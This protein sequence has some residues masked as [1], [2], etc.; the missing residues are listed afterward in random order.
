[1][2]N[3]LCHTGHLEKYRGFAK[4]GEGGHVYTPCT[5]S[6]GSY[7]YDYTTFPASLFRM[8]FIFAHAQTMKKRI[9]DSAQFYQYS[10]AVTC[11]QVYMDY[12]TCDLHMALLTTSY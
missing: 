10:A 9:I 11:M 2:C 4:K 1:M 12:S 6:T 7:A 3:V 5:P 8:E